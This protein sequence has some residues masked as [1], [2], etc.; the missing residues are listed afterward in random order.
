MKKMLILIPLWIITSL[1]FGQRSGVSDT[2]SLNLRGISFECNAFRMQDKTIL[3]DPFEMFI[4]VDVINNSTDTILFGANNLRY[5]S[6]EELEF[7]YFEMILNDGDAIGLYVT[8]SCL[9][10]PAGEILSVSARYED[11]DEK[12]IMN[13]FRTFNTDSC[14]DSIQKMLQNC[15]IIYT[16]LP[17]DYKKEK[18]NYHFID[19]TKVINNENF[20]ISYIGWVSG[21]RNS[22]RQ[23]IDVGNTSINDRAWN[24][25][26]E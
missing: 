25:D 17:E 15:Q 18:V 24:N 6:M 12:I 26:L 22:I 11:H 7:G 8:N 21:E 1:I 2:V 9:E 19:S 10:L 14:M 5:Y 16:P 20:I 3:F 13:R 23:D 4:H